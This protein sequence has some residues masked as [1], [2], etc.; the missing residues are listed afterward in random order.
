MPV[1]LVSILEGRSAAE[2][3]A[4]M[5]A[6]QT[7]IAD[8]LK[9]PPQDRNLRLCVHGRDEWLLPEDKTERYVLVEIMLFAGR[10]PETKGALFTAIVEALEGLGIQRNDVFLILNEQPRENVGIR[11]GIRADLVD[12]GYQ[13][14][15]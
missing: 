15:V 11:G 4:L 12:L 9:L 3:R 7:A 2:K 6:V 10:T 5:A 1:T 8:T 14:K 13:V